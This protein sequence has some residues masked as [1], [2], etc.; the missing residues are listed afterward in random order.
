MDISQVYDISALMQNGVYLPAQEIPYQPP[1]GK[2]FAF[3]FAFVKKKTIV[4][5]HAIETCL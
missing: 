1:D 5:T 3:F 2:Y 4:L